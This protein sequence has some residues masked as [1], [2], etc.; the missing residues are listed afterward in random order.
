MVIA[1]EQTA[2]KGR[3]GNRWLSPSNQGIWMSMILR[4]PIQINE[5]SQMTILSSLAIY[6]AIASDTKLA[7]QI[8]WP[9]DLLIGEEN[10]W[11]FHR[12]PRKT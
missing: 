5:A 11:D 8:K 4:P 1:E 2:G 9:N 10:M 7:V 12:N 6:K 3:L